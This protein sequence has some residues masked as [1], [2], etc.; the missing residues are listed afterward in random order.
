MPKVSQLFSDSDRTRIN[1]AVG[2][3]E[4]QT[5]AEIVPVVAASSGRYDRPEDVVGLW[6][7]AG[8]FTAAWYFLPAATMQP[9]HWGGIS[10]AAQLSVFIV[11]IVMGFF[12]GAWAA[13][14]VDWLRRLFTPKAQMRDEVAGRARQVF[15][16]G[17]V[18][19]TAA[20]S[21]LLI[22]V[23]LF[24]HMAEVFGDRS[25]VEKLG[26]EGLDDLCS[27]LRARLR[28]GSPADALVHVLD[29]A[30]ERLGAVLTRAADGRNELPDALVVIE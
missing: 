13:M 10:A 25:V 19:H 6:F 9:G 16:D 28:A 29:A 14:Q 1:E 3:A 18:H 2:R 23:S 5:S 24:E 8:F 27:Q 21:G 17:R 26:Q 11:A 15:F 20:A 12:V 4:A 7:A 30:G 22:Y